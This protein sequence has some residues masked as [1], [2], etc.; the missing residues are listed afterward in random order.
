MTRQFRTER[1]TREPQPPRHAS[2]AGR[3]GRHGTPSRRARQRAGVLELQNLRDSGDSSA[4][5]DMDFGMTCPNLRDQAQ[6]S[7]AAA[8]SH[9]REVEQQ[10]VASPLLDRLVHQLEWDH[11]DFQAPGGAILGRPS[12]RS[13]LKIV[14]SAPQLADYF[15]EGVGPAERLEAG[16]DAHSRSDRERAIGGPSEIAQTG[17]NNQVKADRDEILI[18]REIRSVAGDGIKIGEIERLQ[19]QGFAQ[20]AGQLKRVGTRVQDA[21][22]RLIMMHAGRRRRERR[23]RP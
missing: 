8:C 2:S 9:P 6:G 7:Q 16:D 1:V 13:R 4:G 19:A 10:K 11:S 15:A 18:K 5:T 14:R 12:K 17:I 23:G 3:F 20:G 21:S 22:N